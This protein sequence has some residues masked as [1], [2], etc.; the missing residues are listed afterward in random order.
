MEL[1]ND[2]IYPIILL[3]EKIDRG[4]SDFSQY[5]PAKNNKNVGWRPQ[6]ER[7][8][9]RGGFEDFFQSHFQSPCHT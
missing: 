8:R 9:Y 5:Q 3:Y 2:V 1:S 6:D 4:F 7:R